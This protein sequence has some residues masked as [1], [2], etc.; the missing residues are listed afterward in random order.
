MRSTDRVPMM[1][2]DPDDLRSTVRVEGTRNLEGLPRSGGTLRTVLMI[3]LVAA[4][5]AIGSYFVAKRLGL[6]EKLP[7]PLQQR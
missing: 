3:L 1:A 7:A 6:A 4:L 5:G 2:R